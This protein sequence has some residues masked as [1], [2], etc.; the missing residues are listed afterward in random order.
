MISRRFHAADADKQFKSR[1]NY[2]TTERFD[3]LTKRNTTYA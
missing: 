3:S 1:A 2:T